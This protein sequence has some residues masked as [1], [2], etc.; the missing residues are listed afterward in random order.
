MDKNFRPTDNC[1]R[2]WHCVFDCEQEEVDID[3]RSVS[4]WQKFKCIIDNAIIES[5]VE[6]ICDKFDKEEKE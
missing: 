6:T 3:A 5:P 4:Y 2:C 1:S